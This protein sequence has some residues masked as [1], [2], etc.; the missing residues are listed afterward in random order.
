[1]GLVANILRKKEDWNVHDR[2]SDQLKEIRLRQKSSWFMNPDFE[3][4][5]LLKLLRKAHVL[6]YWHEAFISEVK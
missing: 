2:R 4:E 6:K 5:P 3:H 1:M